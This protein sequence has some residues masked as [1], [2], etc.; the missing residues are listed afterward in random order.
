[1]REYIFKKGKITII[2]LIASIVIATVLQV[3]AFALPT[4]PII[5]NVK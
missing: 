5:K 3:M 1:M 4:G 2:V